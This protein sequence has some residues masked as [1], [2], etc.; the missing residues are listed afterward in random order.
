MLVDARGLPLSALVASA[1]CAEVN[2]IQTLLDVRVLKRKPERL[3]Y[4]KAADADWLRSTLAGQNVELVCPHRK[5]RK[6]PKTQDG[7]KL[8]RYQHRWIIERTISWLQNFRR[9][10][11]R[12]EYY[13]HLFEGFLHLGCLFIILKQF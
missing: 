1:K 6:R 9:L 8:R 12:Y 11:T 5:G 3:I 7:R 2:T 4:D 13:A 10:V